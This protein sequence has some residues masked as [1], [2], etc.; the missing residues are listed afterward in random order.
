MADLKIPNLCGTSPEFNAI[1]TEFEKLIKTAIDGLE[2]DASTLAANALSDLNSLETE[3]RDLIPEVPSLPDVNLQ[4]LLTSLSSLTP[5]S[6]AHTQAL[7]DITSD[8]GTAL[9][10]AGFSLDT[11]VTD[12]LSAIQGGSGL[13]SAVSIPNFTKAADG[14]SDAIEKAPESLQPI[15]DSSSEKLST[16]VPN[17]FIAGVKEDL[18]KIVA[19][20]Q[21]G[22]DIPAGQED[23]YKFDISGNPNLV[24]GTTPPTEDTG[25]L[26]VATLFSDL[27]TTAGNKVKVTTPNDA[28]T[29]TVETNIS[30]DRIHVVPESYYSEIATGELPDLDL[31]FNTDFNYGITLD[32]RNQSWQPTEGYSTSFFQSLPLIQDSS[33]IVNNYSAT[34][35]NEISD[36]AITAIKFQAKSVHGVDEDVRL[37]NRLFMEGKKLRGFARGKVGPKDGSDWVGGNYIMGLSAEVQLPNLLPESYKTDFS[38]YLDAAN[39]WGVDYSDTLNDSNKIRSSFGVA[40]NVY[41]AIGPLSWT[42]SQSITKASTDVTETFNFN[43]GTSF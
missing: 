28:S 36:N 32:K 15:I 11:L 38:V 1:Q 29:K 16:L 21:S 8:F 2:D 10:S 23:A 39:V 12:A 18:S 22:V 27:V 5:G 9:S 41:T 30:G 6:S 4:S 7:A 19:S 26:I 37:T 43:L 31:D 34:V 42:F 14:L 3:L 25:V 40:A 24:S 35:Y 17:T 33:S 13:C 20:V